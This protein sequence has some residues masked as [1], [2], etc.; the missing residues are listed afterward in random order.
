MTVFTT[1]ILDRV[2]GWWRAANYL[3]IGQIYL[4]DNPLLREPL[5]REHLKAPRRGHWAETP[6]LNFIYV[7]L[8]RLIR[9]HDLTMKYVSG[10]GHIGPGLVANAYLEGTHSEVYPEVSQDADGMKLLFQQFSHSGAHGGSGLGY[11][12]S[13]AYGAVFDHPNLIACCVIG[14][15][16]AEIGP[17]PT[18]WHSS[19]SLNPV[20]DGAALPILHL[21][22][23]NIAGPTSAA[24]MPREELEQLLRSYGHVPYFVEGDESSTMHQQMSETLDRIRGEILDIQFEARGCGL[25]GKPLW[26][27]IVLCS[28]RSWTGPEEVDQLVHREALDR[29]EDVRQLESW[30][31]SYQPGA[32]F[33]D[34]GALKSDLAVLSPKGARR[35]SANP[36][37][38]DD[39]PLRDRG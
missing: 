18:S 37:A 12:L 24:G 26:P 39:I 4:R 29:P 1:P 17:L 21:N 15:G 5:R 20:R 10:P 8:N 36:L 23:R 11:A 32:L 16:E 25:I 31:K 30:M 38:N 2:D 35:M 3:S 28:P 33:D 9:E 14:N 34:S 22:G 19:R 13:H 7:H 6:A 27:M